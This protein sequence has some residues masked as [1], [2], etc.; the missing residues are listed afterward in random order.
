MFCASCGLALHRP[1][2][3][4]RPDPL[5]LTTLSTRRL[6]FQSMPVGSP[7]R[8][9]FSLRRDPARRPERRSRPRDKLIGFVEQPLRRAPKGEIYH[10]AL[11]LVVEGRNGLGFPEDRPVV[12]I[13]PEVERVTRHHPE[14]QPVAEHARLAEHTA[15][16][17]APERGELL[18]Q[19][20]G[21][22]VAGNHP[23]SSRQ[24]RR[25]GSAGDK[26]L[27]RTPE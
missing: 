14:Y 4:R 9:P 25:F 16:C 26:C 3:R 2:S 15:Y 11:F 7:W 20:L 10:A 5:F 21:K 12:V 17:D 24:A 6:L 22:A 1:P 23:P 27:L 8:C 13:N 19:E 18:P